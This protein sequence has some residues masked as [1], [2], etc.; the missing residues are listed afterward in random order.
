[1]IWQEETKG[2]FERL[3]ETEKPDRGGA[4]SLPGKTSQTE[5]F[6]KAPG[7]RKADFAWASCSVGLLP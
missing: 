6:E 7:R 5:V 2:R 3:A 1:M 4:G